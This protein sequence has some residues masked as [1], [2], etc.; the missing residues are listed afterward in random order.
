MTLRQ[1]GG[2]FT[3]VFA[4]VAG[5]AKFHVAG[6]SLNGEIGV[7]ELATLLVTIFIAVFV[8]SQVSDRR[9]EKDLLMASVREALDALRRC[10]ETSWA[11]FEAEK[12]G[13]SEAGREL[14]RH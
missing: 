14:V 11:R 7:V 5:L 2:V 12:R 8:T 6:L 10:R 9:A 13:R 3:A 1:Q 4:V